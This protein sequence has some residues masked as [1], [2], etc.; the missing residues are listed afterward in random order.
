[1]PSSVCNELLSYTIGTIGFHRL[2]RTMP[3]LVGSSRIYYDFKIKSCSPFSILFLQV[4][5]TKKTS[6]TV[7]NIIAP[8]LRCT[9]VDDWRSGKSPE[10]KDSH[11]Y[12]TC[13]PTYLCGYGWQTHPTRKAESLPRLCYSTIQHPSQNQHS[14]L[15][16]DF[17]DAW[18]CFHDEKVEKNDLKFSAESYR[19]CMH[20]S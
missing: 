10:S 1:M 7:T 14:C 4:Q 12:R 20:S 9:F 18:M 11:F 6:L 16:T 19:K 15:M 5:V 17:D 2:A 13:V 8:N 3:T